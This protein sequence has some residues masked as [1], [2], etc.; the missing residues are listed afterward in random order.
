MLRARVKAKVKAKERARAMMT[1][2]AGEGWHVPPF[3]SMPSL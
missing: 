2:K 1:A 3:A